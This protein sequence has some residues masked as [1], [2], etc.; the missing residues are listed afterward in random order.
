VFT[1]P[2]T[3]VF[4]GRIAATVAA[5]SRERFKP[6]NERFALLKIVGRQMFTNCERDSCQKRCPKL[7]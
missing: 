3:L 2:K 6:K 1:P 7:L 5:G 4:I